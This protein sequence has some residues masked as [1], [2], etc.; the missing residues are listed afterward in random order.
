MIL[1]ILLVL[2]ILTVLALLLGSLFI[3]R[4]FAI[5]ERKEKH[6]ELRPEPWGS[7]G[8]R[9]I[10]DEKWFHTLGPDELWMEKNGIR[11]H[12]WYVSGR[13]DRTVILIHGWKDNAERR[14]DSARFYYERGWNIFIPDLRSH[15]K[16]DGKYVGMGVIERSD[17]IDWITLLTERYGR[18]EVLLDGISMGA[19]TT[20]ALTGD[21]DLP[22]CVKAAISDSA[23]TSIWELVPSLMDPLPNFIRPLFRILTE[24]WCR[25]F[26]GYGFRQDEPVSKVRHSKTPTLFIHGEKDDFVPFYMGKKMYDACSAPKEYW[27]APEAGHILAW[28]LNQEEYERRVDAFINKYMPE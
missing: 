2:F 10:E 12:S 1:K 18:T 26:A 25:I 3:F 27:A 13:K 11:L 6:R 28:W 7:L 20:C 17:I 19:A 15:G 14:M 22:V 5:N 9:L 24:I 4:S 8:R 23:Y 16:S 21:F